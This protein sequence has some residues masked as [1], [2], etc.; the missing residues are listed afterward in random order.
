MSEKAGSYRPAGLSN[1]LRRYA[2][3]GI[4]FFCVAI[5]YYAA[6][7]DHASFVR[8][9]HFGALSILPAIS[10]LAICFI[11][12]NVILALFMG[13]VVGGLITTDYNIVQKFLIPSLGTPR[14]AEI[15]LVY[16]W[17][18][19]GL[20]GLWNRN[21]GAWHFASYV[22]EKFV[23][24]RRSAMFFTWLMGILF[25][26]GGTISTVLTGTTVRP[27]ADREKVA[28]EELAYIVDSTASPIA[29]IIPFNVWPVYVA[30]LIAIPSLGQYVP[31]R[32][33][34]ISLFLHAIPFNF[35]GWFAILFTLLFAL[36][37]LPFVGKRMRA[38][39]DRVLTT[40]ELDHPDADPMISREL[41]TVNVA[42]GYT[43]SLLDFFVPIGVLMSVAI[44]PYLLVG[45]LMIFEAFSLALVSAVVLSMIRG[46]SA[47]DAFDALVDGI[48]GVTVGAV[49]L[50]LAVTLATVSETLG[51]SNWVI[52]ISA[53]NLSAAPFVLPGL[54]MIICMF[55]AFSVG[56]SWGTYAVVF[57]IAL[58]LAFAI[59]SDPTYVSLAFAA[60]MGG[61]VFGD[62]CSP[63]SDTTI[64]ASLACGADLMDHVLT[65]LPIAL[66][67]AG[68]S[69]LLYTGIA[70]AIL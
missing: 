8:Q 38:A 51:A 4:L 60:I 46:M 64:L 25:H 52:E 56:S 67:A 53:S 1:L 63:I 26:Q 21:G 45:K 29:T 7:T 19:G 22:S 65:Q 39:R 27:V 70:L 36:G 13:I 33:A 30:G 44:V 2:W 48:K 35:Y 5:G 10:A 12:R 49:I 14:Y 55:V 66:A 17:A 40:G 54:L 28:H 23:K 20:L 34:G 24:S 58:P 6:T 11:T 61:A 32:D 47:T 3:L 68:I 59:S 37:K 42:P 50:G 57:P 62:Q 18:L 69:I 43:P 41:T 31:D 15:L 9:Q 16:L